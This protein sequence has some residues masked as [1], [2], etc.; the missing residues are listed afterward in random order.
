[1]GR[2]SVHNVGWIEWLVHVT[3]NIAPTTPAPG[4]D[5]AL[6]ATIIERH[7]PLE[8]AAL[9]IL[10]ALQDQFACVP[11]EA[12]PLIA[13]ALNISRAEIHGI[14]SFYHDFRRTPPGRHVLKLCRAEACQSMGGTNV[15][16]ALLAR[17][18]I[19]WGGTT[20]DGSLT[21]DP[22]YCL[23]LCACAP[24]ALLDGEPVA[25]LDTASLAAIVAQARA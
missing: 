25:R 3:A 15:S 22:V 19:D 1:M 9:P 24:A 6:A 13:E 4:W 2:R 14:I 5:A 18:G 23:G 7:L 17:L 8:G 10:H 16:E 12:E 21:V 11:K 20:T